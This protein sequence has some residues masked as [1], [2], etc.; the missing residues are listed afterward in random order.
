V[1]NLYNADTTNLDINKP[2]C[3]LE[4]KTSANC[5]KVVILPYILEF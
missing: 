5:K 1:T 4:R 3:M 2:V